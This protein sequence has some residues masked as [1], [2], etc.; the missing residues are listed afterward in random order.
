M[1]KLKGIKSDATI[2]GI[3]AIEMIESRIR[4]GLP[5]YKLIFLD[6]SMPE[7]DGP[8]TSIEICNLCQQK[9][10]E[11][12]YI[13]CV[14]AYS[15]PHYKKN[16]LASGMDDLIVKPVTTVKLKKVIDLTLKKK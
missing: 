4:S 9:G 8:Q 7:K 12:P 14:T 3:E 5:C 10:I 16:A 6:Y 2:S 1:L 13:C 11:K 15:E